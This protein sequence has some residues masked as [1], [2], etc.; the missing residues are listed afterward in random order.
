MQTKIFIGFYFCASQSFIDT[1]RTEPGEVVVYA[2]KAKIRQ[3]GYILYKDNKNYW[4][5]W[6]G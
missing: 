3:A 5:S 2:T 6:T 4:G 1:C